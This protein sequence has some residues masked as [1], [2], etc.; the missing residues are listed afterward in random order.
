MSALASGDAGLEY[1]S[2]RDLKAGG[3]LLRRIAQNFSATTVMKGAHIVYYNLSG[4]EC[5][6]LLDC[7]AGVDGETG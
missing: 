6:L 2:Q 5:P 1:R 4:I 7:G 3:S